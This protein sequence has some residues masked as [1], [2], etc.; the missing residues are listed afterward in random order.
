METFAADVTS[1]TV[2]ELAPG[3]LYSFQVS[4]VSLSAGEGFR[5]E[6]HSQST[7]PA[8]PLWSDP[9]SQHQTASTILLSW[10][11]PTILTGAAVEGYT[12][13]R[14][15][16]LGGAIETVVSSRRESSRSRRVIS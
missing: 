2:V 11:A 3:L 10:V 7:A 9:H 6:V 5:G 12:V 1:T 8:A 15:A 14:D 13:Y 4:A 16:G